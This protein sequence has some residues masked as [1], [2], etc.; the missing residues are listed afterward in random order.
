MSEREKWMPCRVRLCSVC[1]AELRRIR[2]VDRGDLEWVHPPEPI[3]L[4]IIGKWRPVTV[5][6][7]VERAL[8]ARHK[9]E[10]IE[11]K[12]ACLQSLVD[13]SIGF[14]HAPTEGMVLDDIEQYQ[15]ELAALDKEVTP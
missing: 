6:E 3:A 7:Y 5:T 11:A 2:E 10:L 8:E 15:A 9:R 13:A 1:G 14:P 12:I 4:C